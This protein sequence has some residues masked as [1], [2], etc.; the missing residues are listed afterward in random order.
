MLFYDCIILR[1]PRLWFPSEHEYKL[2]II[3]IGWNIESN[4][5]QK[6]E[7]DWMKSDILTLTLIFCVDCNNNDS[8]LLKY[9]KLKSILLP[10]TNICSES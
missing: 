10:N 7:S 3:S 2:R 6:S 8:V 1:S 9:E 5:H 4:T